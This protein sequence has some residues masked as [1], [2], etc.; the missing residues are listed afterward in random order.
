MSAPKT[1]SIAL[2]HLAPDA[3]SAGAEL[4]DAQLTAVTP[5]K[6]RALLEAL[7]VL[8]PSIEYP[9]APE[10]R[11]K[12][13]SDHFVVQVKE[14]RI[15]FA[16][17]SVR[18]GGGELTPR[19]ILA[20]I[21]G[22]EEEGGPDFAGGLAGR[23]AGLPRASKGALLAAAILVSN[24]ITAWMLTRPPPDMLP[25]YRLMESE[26]GTRLLADVAGVY[27]TGSAQGDR[28]LTIHADGTVRWVTFGNNR[29]IAETSDLTA[30]P[31]LT[32]GRPALLTNTRAL[33]EIREPV[34]VVFYGDIYHRK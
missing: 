3:K 20:A 15:R 26:P 33:I 5:E 2:H 23:A 29:T 27:E 19:Q 17:W 21:A 14:G 18:T 6:L 28:S 16:S 32:G 25:E 24:G 10:M 31:V 9:V 13:D 22:I 7:A 34:R 12:S 1:F 8:A 11:I 4:A 30:Q